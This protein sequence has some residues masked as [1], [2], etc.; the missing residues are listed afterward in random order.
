MT[1]WILAGAAIAGIVLGLAAERLWRGFVSMRK[2]V[3]TRMTTFLTKLRWIAVTAA[4]VAAV[5][6]AVFKNN[7]D[8]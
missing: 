3:A 2:Q 7:A 5:L 1:A 8:A 4:V 6:L